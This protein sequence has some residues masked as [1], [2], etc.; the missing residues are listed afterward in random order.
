MSGERPVWLLDV[1]GVIN[2]VCFGVPDGYKRIRANGYEITYDPAIIARIRRLHDSGAVEVR[3]LTTWCSDADTFLAEPLQMVRSLV[4]EG[5]LDH[6]IASGWWKSTAARRVSD[7]NP[8]AALIW[9]DDDLSYSESKGE[10]DWLRERTG[11]TLA[12]STNPMTGLTADNLDR[13]EAFVERLAAKAA[14]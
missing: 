9:T 10:V 14:S 3:W 1:D 2:A 4:V 8:D 7:A 11:P 13:I 12:I 6:R 5:E